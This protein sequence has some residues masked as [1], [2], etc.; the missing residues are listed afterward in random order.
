MPDASVVPMHA[1]D[2]FALAA[3]LASGVLALLHGLVWR[4]QRARWSLVFAFAYAVIATIYAF[5]APL[6]PSGGQPHPVAGLLAIVSAVAM[7]LGM[8]EYVGLPARTAR[9]LRWVAVAVAVLMTVL[10]SGQLV[11]R[12]VGFVVLSGYLVAQAGLALYAMRQEPQR[13]HGLV[14]LALLSYPA[15]IAAAALGLYDVALLR[16]AV[17]VPTSVMGMTLLTTGLLRAQQVARDELSGRVRAEAELRS[18]NEALEQRVLQRTE[19]L[20]GMVTALES[21][22]RSISH[23]LR[24]PLGGIAGVSRLATEALAAGD[25]DRASRLL[26]AITRQADSSAELVD[27]LL[28][29]ARVDDSS[30][31]P[32]RVPL[33]DVVADSLTALRLGDPG[34]SPPPVHVGPLPTLHVDPA[35]MRQVFVNL[36]GNALKFSQGAHA[37][38]VEVG[39]HVDDVGAHV[40]FV[41]DNALGFDPA[42]ATELFEP[43]RQLHA[44]RHGGHGVGLSIVRRIVERHGGRVWAD[45]ATGAG[46]TFYVRLGAPA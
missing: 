29:L 10:I 33:A 4:A 26:P 1:F 19:A 35:L 27:A 28:A 37:P 40:L 24:G 6:R 3:A 21:F 8:V 16:Y 34:A 46:A 7:T 45:A 15:V 39:A 17:A 32:R 42:T 31:S 20:H 13:G 38:R 5:D 44:G 18:L 9:R 2:V 30:L 25:T 23:D 22:N 43:F 12:L 14:A 11:S 41:R 36:I